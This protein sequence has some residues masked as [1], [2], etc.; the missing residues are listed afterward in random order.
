MSSRPRFRALED[1]VEEELRRIQEASATPVPS[2]TTA[3]E[4]DLSGVLW[5]YCRTE[6][7]FPVFTNLSEARLTEIRQY[8]QPFLERHRR[9]GPPPKISVNDSL[10]L[11]LY[12][13]KTGADFETTATHMR[14]KASTLRAAV[15]RIRPVLNETLVSKW[16]SERRRPRPFEGPYPY[17]A[18]A[19]DG[20]TIPCY[21]PTGPFHEAKH[22][23]SAHHGLYGVNYE[24]AVLASAPHYCLFVQPGVPGSVHDYTRLKETYTAYLDYLTKTTTEQTMIE[25]D[26]ENASWAVVC[27][28]AYVGPAEDTPGF[29]KI[30]GKKGALTAADRQRN[31]ELARIRVVVEQFFG[32]ANNLWACIRRTYKWDHTNIDMDVTNCF[33]LTNEH[34]KGKSLDTSDSDF[35][36]QEQ[37]ARL[38]HHEEKVGRK[39]ASYAKSKAAKRRRIGA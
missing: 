27:D 3:E 2:L 12:L 8:M 30:T 29:R 25:S 10:I 36:L 14:Y 9:R 26:G 22:Y 28:L 39:R 4:A 13:Y 35:Y 24:V 11:L 21:R 37:E 5:D 31:Q 32:R 6:D 15:E 18:L 19:L 23:W 20:T 17:I 34:I 16:W 38:K 33:L 7:K 1:I